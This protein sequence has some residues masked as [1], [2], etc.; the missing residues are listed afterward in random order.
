MTVV[1]QV[2]KGHPVAPLRVRMSKKERLRIRWEG[3]DRF[4]IA[5]AMGQEVRRLR[6]A[7][8]RRFHVGY[9]K[10]MKEER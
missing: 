10:L 6:N 5:A 4:G 7:L 1:N 3:R 8:K 2:V 9:F